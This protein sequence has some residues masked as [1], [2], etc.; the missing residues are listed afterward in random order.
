MATIRIAG[1][2]DGRLLD[3]LCRTRN[4]RPASQR[5]VDRIVFARWGAEPAEDVVLAQCGP[6]IWEV[7]C[8]G[9]SAAVAR[10][11]DDL[12][13]AG[14]ARGQP[15]EF[16][17]G[18][19]EPVRLAWQALARASTLRTADL[20]LHQAQSAWPAAVELLAAAGTEEVR[21]LIDEMLSWREFGRRLADRWRVSIAGRPNAGKSSLMNALAGFARSIVHET[22]GTTRDAVTLETAFEGWPIELIDTAGLRDSED[23]IESE[24][25]R[26]AREAAGRSD[27][28]L[29]VVDGSR[30]FAPEDGELLAAHPGA[31][32]VINKRDLGRIWSLPAGSPKGD[33]LELSARTG[34]GL[35]PLVRA[36]IARLTPA[37][38]PRDL[39]YP[40]CDEQVAWLRGWRPGR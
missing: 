14:C 7:H 28:V 5:G 25:V 40:V 4:G 37:L 17:P 29:L 21:A 2:G 11:L 16:L 24:G 20:L 33:C 30:P 3:G 36:I 22:P 10:I 18:A 38:P 6:G 1:A 9:G 32:R 27:L 39:A 13:A 23:P 26:R 12:T 8:H 19:S 34:E 35:D 15:A 31:L